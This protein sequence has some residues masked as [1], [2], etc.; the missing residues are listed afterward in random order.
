[1]KAIKFLI[2]GLLISSFNMQAQVSVN[3]NLET[4]PVW[5]PAD[6]VAVQYYYLPGGG[7]HDQ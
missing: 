3:V 1:M 7:G 5:A 2:L 4:P 6:R